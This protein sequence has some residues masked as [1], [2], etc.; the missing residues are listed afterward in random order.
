MFLIS[1]FSSVALT[2]YTAYHILLHGHSLFLPHQYSLSMETDGMDLF[3]F[4][5][6]FNPKYWTSTNGRNFI[7]FS[8]WKHYSVL[9]VQPAFGTKSFF[10]LLIDGCY[11]PVFLFHLRKFRESH[12]KYLPTCHLF[13]YVHAGI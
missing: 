12:W 5:Y 2:S 7:L 10:S 13:I 8:E 6:N 1:I 11:G 9:L 4:H 3:C